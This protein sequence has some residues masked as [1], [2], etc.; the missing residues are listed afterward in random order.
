LRV[1]ALTS[2]REGD[3]AQVLAVAEALGAPVEIRR[4]RN[5]RGAIAV[6]LIS[7][8]RAAGPLVVPLDEIAAPWPELVIA[9]GTQSEPIL[10]QLRTAARDTKQV[11]L[12]RPWCSPDR[13]DLVVTT[14]Q[15]RVPAAPNVMELDLPLHRVT[16]AAIERE[17]AHWE[18]RL[19]HLPRPWIVVLIGGSINRYTLDARAA[20][21]IAGEAGARGGSLLICNS[22]RTPQ[23]A[24]PALTKALTVPAFIFDW[25]RAPRS[26]N[27]YLAFLG[28]GDEIVVT[29]DSIS[30]LAEACSTGKP[31][32]IFDLGEGRY[33]MR[34]DAGRSVSSPPL[35]SAIRARLKDLKV[36]ATNRILP[37][38][39]HRDTRPIHQRLIES[40]RAVWL[41]EAFPE[42]R[43]AVLQ[44]DAAAVAARIRALP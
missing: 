14:P 9:A 5:R 36:R 26:E 38:R 17:A 6:N 33:A 34:P 31:V 13:Y 23:D 32:H 30:M 37:A 43:G 41:G 22:Y 2:S 21:R 40:G 7:G 39:L 35:A 28:L 18:A 12:G 15:Y 4:F 42:I 11:F 3:N 1:W 16:A 24:I 29:G 19:A 25:H 20:Q 44:S 10:A 27:P 8:A